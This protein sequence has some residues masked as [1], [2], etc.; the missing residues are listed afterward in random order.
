LS[1]KGE[2]KISELLIL[3]LGPPCPPWCDSS[4]GCSTTDKPGLGQGPPWCDF[5]NYITALLAD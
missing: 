1:R 2:E 4:V 3:D 5:K